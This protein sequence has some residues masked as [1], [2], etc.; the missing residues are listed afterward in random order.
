MLLS[1]VLLPNTGADVMFYV[2]THVQLS[3][4]CILHA[5]LSLCGVRRQTH[6]CEF[7]HIVW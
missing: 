2:N 4:T 6:M 3:V 7:I 1:N 5:T